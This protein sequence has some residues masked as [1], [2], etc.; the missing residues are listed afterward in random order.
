MPKV[1]YGELWQ[2]LNEANRIGMRRVIAKALERAKTPAQRKRI[3]ESQKYF[4]S[5][6]AEI[7]AWKRFEGIYPGCSAESNVSHVYAARK[8]SPPMA[9]D[10]N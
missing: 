4:E 5:Q 9:W 1:S 7:E 8:S 2:T 3:L 6:W 10:S